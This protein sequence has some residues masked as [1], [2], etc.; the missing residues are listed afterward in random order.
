MVHQT[1]SPVMTDDQLSDYKRFPDV[2]FGR[3]QP[4]PK[5]VKTRVQL[6]DSLLEQNQE[7]PRDI[8]L[9]FFAGHHEIQDI[10]NMTTED[11]RALYCEEMVARAVASGFTVD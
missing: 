6:F 10:K 8:S 9:G 3:L 4:T 5:I 2:S 11:L 1:G 7:M